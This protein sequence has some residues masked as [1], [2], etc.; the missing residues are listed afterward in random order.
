MFYSENRCEIVIVPHN[1]TNKFQPLHRNVNKAAKVFIQIQYNDWFFKRSRPS[2]KKRPISR[3]Y[4]NC[5]IW[6]LSIPVGLLI[7]IIIYKENVKLLWKDFRKLVLLRPSEIQKLF[8]KES[9]T[10]LG[11]K[12]FFRRLYKYCFMFEEKKV[13]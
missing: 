11:C 8:T 13:W 9:K 12:T 5:Q 10:R 6:N 7:C 3:Y 1:L 2:I 4:L